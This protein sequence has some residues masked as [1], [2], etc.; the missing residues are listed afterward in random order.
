MYRRDINLQEK[1][2]E[3][4]SE[5]PILA[6]QFFADYSKADSGYIGDLVSEFCDNDVDVYYKD[7]LNWIERDND[8]DYYM[9]EV[10]RRGD[11]NLE[12]YVFYEHVQAAQYCQNRDVMGEN[13]YDGLFALQMLMDMGVKEMPEDEL[14]DLLTSLLYEDDLSVIQATIEEVAAA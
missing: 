9:E 13:R 12:D 3:I 4:L 5:L 8:A 10:M 7:L 14:R 6:V 1:M 2:D 11:V